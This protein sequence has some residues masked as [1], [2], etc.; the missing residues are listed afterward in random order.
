MK[1]VENNIQ[2]ISDTV[3]TEQDT[4]KTISDIVKTE[5]DSIQTISDTV[6]TEQDEIKKLKQNE[7]KN[8][9]LTGGDE[10]HH[11]NSG[12]NNTGR[13]V[14]NEVISNKML[15]QVLS[16]DARINTSL[17][18]LYC[19]SNPDASDCSGVCV[20][21]TDCGPVPD[22]LEKAQLCEF[23]KCVDVSTKS[24]RYHQDCLDQPSGPVQYCTA[25]NDSDTP[26]NCAILTSDKY[27]DLSGVY[28]YK[29]MIDGHKISKGKGKGTASPYPYYKDLPICNGLVELPANQYAQNIGRVD[30]FLSSIDFKMPPVLITKPFGCRGTEICSEN[31]WE[32]IA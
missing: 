14:L 21:D 11:K 18:S 6:K 24:C 22:N 3:K 30:K 26:G 31:V 13:N 28:P 25:N 12:W 23:G 29:G 9:S 17:S 16:S 5:Q 10:F 1:T 20:T 32:T 15:G 4:M 27:N 2:T 8:D 19:Q 7:D